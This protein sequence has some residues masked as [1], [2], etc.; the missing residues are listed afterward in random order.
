MPA[1]PPPGPAEP[2]DADLLIA[3][4]ARDRGAFVVLF[5]RYAGRIKAFAM[6]SGAAAADAEEIAQDVMVAIWRRAASYDPARAAAATW[7]YAMARNRRIDMIRRA[8]RPVPD[9]D[10]PLWRPDPE[11]DGLDLVSQAER[12]RRVRDSLAA[13][14]PEQRAVLAAAFYDGLSHAEIALAQGVPLGTVKSRLRLA[15]RRL[16]GVLGDDLA[17]REDDDG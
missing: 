8:R 14:A 15:F 5:E 9:P 11:P 3:V 4:A 12:E 10:D 1:S 6:R 16:R 7:I 13:L 2:S 17:H